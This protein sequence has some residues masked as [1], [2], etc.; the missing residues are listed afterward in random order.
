MTTADDLKE[1]A[2]EAAATYAGVLAAYG[3]A[4]SKLIE[5]AAGD[6]WEPDDATTDAVID[7]VQTLSAASTQTIGL[8]RRWLEAASEL[9]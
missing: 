3:A 1:L 7:V 2:Q 5:K 6:D 8:S 9:T 4:S